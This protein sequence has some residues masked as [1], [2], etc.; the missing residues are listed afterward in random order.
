[1]I[2]LLWLQCPGVEQVGLAVT[3]YGALKCN[4]AVVNV[5]RNACAFS[6]T[7]IYLCRG[8]PVEVETP[9]GGASVFKTHTGQ[10]LIITISSSLLSNALH[11][12][13]FSSLSHS[14]CICLSL[15]CFLIAWHD[16]C[17]SFS[18]RVPSVIC[19]Y[20]PMQTH[21]HRVLL[22]GPAEYLHYRHSSK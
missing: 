22:R 21:S 7:S 10:T 8:R 15:M 12:M 16:V 6:T 11:T 13:T 19:F 14:R 4:R 5:V 1:M 9:V 2:W 17:V 3:A 20:A 18:A